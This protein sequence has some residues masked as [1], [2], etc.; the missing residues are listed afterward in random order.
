MEAVDGV[1]KIFVSGGFCNG[2]IA[3][4]RRKFA[5]SDSLGI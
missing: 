1:P 4:P 5:I 2:E 3:D